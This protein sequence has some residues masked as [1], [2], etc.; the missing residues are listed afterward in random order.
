M[1]AYLEDESFVTLFANNFSHSEGCVLILNTVSFFCAKAFKLNY[2]KSVFIFITLQDGSRKICN[3]R[4]RVFFLFF[5]A[6]R[7]L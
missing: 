7:F 2:I 3:L 1:F 4:Q 5:P 6:I